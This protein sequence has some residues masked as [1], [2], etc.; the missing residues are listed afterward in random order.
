MACCLCTRDVAGRVGDLRRELDSQLFDSGD[1]TIF[2]K[3]DR[4]DDVL[5][6]V[7]HAREVEGRL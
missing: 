1:E 4:V 6:D 2:S 7:D 5:V 3:L